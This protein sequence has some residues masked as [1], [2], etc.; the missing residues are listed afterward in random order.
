M[1]KPNR[2]IL[3]SSNDEFSAIRV[4]PAKSPLPTDF[5]DDINLDDQYQKFKL[6]LNK[7]HGELFTKLSANLLQNKK[8]AE[9]LQGCAAHGAAMRPQIISEDHGRADSDRHTGRQVGW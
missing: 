3:Q 2:F 1:Q 4:N 8:S 6:D 9:P 7:L 5:I